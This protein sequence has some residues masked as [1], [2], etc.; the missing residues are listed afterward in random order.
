MSQADS[1][2]CRRATRTIENTAAADV[3][4]S[5]EESKE[6]W[7]VVNTYEV[8]G[9]RYFDGLDPKAMHLWG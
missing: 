4:L 6:V 9:N 8:K 2:N 1:W 5:E 3:K 7:N